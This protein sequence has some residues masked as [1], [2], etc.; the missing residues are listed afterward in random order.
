MQIPII[1]GIYSDNG[2]DLRT[3]YPRNLVPVPK[4]SG[5]ANGYLRQA[6]GL[7]S[8]GT[9]PGISRGGINW[10]GTLYRVMGSKL[11]RISS[12]GSAATITSSLPGSD[13][14]RLVYSFDYLAIAAGGQLWL[15]D[16]ATL[17]QVT[18]TDLGTVN[19]VIWVDGYFM[20]TDGENLVVTELGD[21]FTVNP[22]KYGSSEIDPD[23]VKCLLKLRGEVYAINR[24]TIEVFNNVGGDFFPFARVDGA[25]I[26]QG[27]VGARAAAVFADAIAFVGGGRDDSPAVWIGLNGAAQ[28]ISTREIEQVL[29]GLNDTQLEAIV[30]ETRSDGAHE[31]LWMRM[32]DRT[33]VYDVAASRE[34]GSP[35]WFVLTTSIVG[36]AQHR[37]RDLVYCYNQWNVADTA[38]SA[39]GVLDRT[40]SAHWGEVNGWDFGTAIVY[41][42]AR[43][44]LFH[45]LELVA[46]TG[47]FEL[48]KS[49]VVWTQYSSDGL[50]WTSER[51]AAAGTVGNRDIRI[52]WLSMGHMRRARM[53]RFRGTSDCHIA[54]IR[55]EA[56]V[57]ALAN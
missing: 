40:T 24:Y 19:D 52:V 49:P 54:P 28:K 48:G 26:P 45:E 22:L 8:L 46:L 3:S 27:C 12:N 25:T 2:P 20:T 50:T 44:A 9:G 57:E 38:S 7:V 15:Y 30:L 10:N 4:V 33:L 14:V 11:V 31:H 36:F 53:Q 41:A 47:R 35:V 23:P 34:L 32:P 6:E 13:N 55:L 17:A 56:R 16:G 21:P 5:I 43:G 18:D 29:Q 1:N 37:C 39:F 42:D 51:P